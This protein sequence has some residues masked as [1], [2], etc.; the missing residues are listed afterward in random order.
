MSLIIL[1]SKGSDPEDFS[2]FITE[3]IKFPADAEVCLVSSH[4]NRKMMVQEEVRLEAGAN[5]LG[6]QFGSGTLDALRATSGYTPHSPSAWEI[7]E[8]DNHFPVIIS[9][10]E[11]PAL[12]N[13]FMNEAKYQ[14]I[15]P[16]VGGWITDVTGGK[17]IF[18]NELKTPDVAS[19]R[20]N[21][22]VQD[23]LMQPGYN[24]IIG[25]G[26]NN[27]DI[28]PGNASIAQP[29]GALYVDWVGCKGSNGGGSCNFVDIDPVWNTDTG[30]RLT[31]LNPLGGAGACIEGGA[32]TW[33]FTTDP[34]VPASEVMGLRGGIFSSAD[35]SGQTAQ[36][37]SI[38]LSKITGGTDFSLWWE[39]TRY[40]PAGGRISIDFC[41]RQPRK[42]GCKDNQRDGK[43]IWGHV[44]SVP[45]N[46]AVRIGMRPVQYVIGG[47]NRYVIEGFYGRA[48]AVTNA[49]T[50]PPIVVATG[51]DGYIKVTDP[52]VDEGANQF[53]LYRH[54]PLRMGCCT[55]R[56]A[57][58]LVMNAIHHDRTTHLN[59]VAPAVATSP[60]FTFCLGD[61]TQTDQ[62][63]KKFDA[64]VRQTL[65]KATIGAS[66]GFINGSQ[67]QTAT[68]MATTGASAEIELGYVIPVA[69]PLV[70]T[71]PDLPITGFYGNSAGELGAG[72]LNLNSGG[73]SSAILGVI[74]YG[75]K[76]FRDPAQL[77]LTGEQDKQK[78]EFFSCPMEN[79]I[80]LNNPTAFSVS[81]L[82]VK[83]TDA[84]GQKPD[85]L[86]PNSTITIKIRNSRSS[87]DSMRQGGLASNF[88]NQ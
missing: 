27:T 77:I 44:D 24:Q 63:A 52:A 79:Y 8:V 60:D 31:T 75:D 84:L 78:G 28:L 88:R 85:V 25:G 86:D 4:I 51:Q 34:A 7:A 18:K 10:V 57:P 2:N 82:R 59:M 87:R 70:V 36:N 13:A 76:P 19:Q 12:A 67:V 11:V 55:Q 81:S 69:K 53:D 47:E 80:Q 65:R 39:I 17:L 83:I 29:A 40:D 62:S 46:D 6:F 1:S 30:Q 9:G 56:E 58:A 20:G 48:D 38:R 35:F 45:S 22:R 41:A 33:G 50:Q 16:L 37:Q 54:L 71:L 32:W 73:S 74:P 64:E 43:I 15:S 66:L 5:T 3:Q 72:T 14:P 49:W 21:S 42:A 68:L 61:I 23:I 26:I